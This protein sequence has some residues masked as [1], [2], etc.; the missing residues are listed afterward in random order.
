[1]SE[2]KSIGRR[3]P[4]Q[5][6]WFLA[7]LVALWTLLF[8]MR[9]VGPVDLVT[10]SQGLTLSYLVDIITNG[11]WITA[12]D[13]LGDPASKPPLHNWLAVLSVLGFGRNWFAAALPGALATL[14]TV[15]WLVWW[16]GKHLGVRTGSAA[17]FVFL[18][19]QLTVSLLPVVRPDTLFTFCVAVAAGYA[20][21]AWR[22]IRS[23]WPFW[24][25]VTL[26]GLTKGPLGLVL[27]AA[28]LT[29]ALVMRRDQGRRRRTDGLWLG[30]V[31]FLAV[32]VGWFVAGWLT[33][34][35]AF[36]NELV[37]EELVGHAVRNDRGDSLITTFWQ[38]T[39]YLL[40]RFVPWSILLFWAIPRVIRRPAGDREERA[41]E[42]F[43]T[44]WLVVGLVLFSFAGH[45]RA[46]LIAPL[47]PAAALL[48]GRQLADWTR[49]W[50]RNRLLV[51]SG[52]TT[53]ALLIGFTYYQYVSRA[54]NPLIRLSVAQHA[55]A[56]D[57]RARVSDGNLLVYTTGDRHPQFYYI[58]QFAYGTLQRPIEVDDALDV[59]SGTEDAW[60]VAQ[61]A[62]LV[63]QLA[64]NRGLRPHVLLT[65][66]EGVALVSNNPGFP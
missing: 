46:D 45:K 8:V 38:P 25:W 9:L 59:L 62:D 4:N 64:E 53:A 26:A 17:A 29:A 50:T 18:L 34:G 60:I 56:A 15:F 5:I 22:G 27:A 43:L 6:R 36:V 61:D 1:M 42:L 32:N 20:F 23:W 7:A 16:G 31:L 44:A 2:M 14:A 13:N 37:V 33:L 51:A 19:S 49:N 28:G 57:L 65:G 58:P 30:L 63:V 41:V 54:R 10:K 52:L 12:Q 66:D 55:F 11:H 39:A 21:E 47:V 24:I 35:S 40:G 48:V 3:G